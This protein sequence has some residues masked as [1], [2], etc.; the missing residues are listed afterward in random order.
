VIPARLRRPGALA[1]AL[2]TPFFLGLIVVGAATPAHATGESGSI[3]H[4]QPTKDGVRL[5][6][7]AP[8]GSD[9][10]DLAGVK[11]QIG[12]HTVKSEAVTAS[13][14]QATKRVAILAIDTS[15]SM[16]GAR[17]AEAKRAA[18]TYLASAPANVEIGVLTF[19]D[20]VKLLVKPSL[21]RGAAR[22]AINKLTLTHNTALYEGVLGAIQATGAG[23][24]D[25]DQRRILVLSDGK[26]TTQTDL[27][28]VLDTISSS[29]VL[30]DAVA[31]QQ[32]GTES[33]A[34]REMAAAGK[35][36]VLDASSPT[37]LSAAFAQEAAV[38]SRQL[39]VTA[40]VPG[41]AGKNADVSVTMP[42]GGQ[43][44]TAA[45]YLPV[46][47]ATVTAATDMVPTPV[48]SG[49]FQISQNVV[50]GGV[51]AI[52]VGLLGMI[53]A[54][55]SRKPAANTEDRLNAQMSA[56][57]SSAS[58]GGESGPVH[59]QSSGFSG[60]ARGVAERALANNRGLEARLATKLET[61]GLA[62]KPA[63][64]LLLRAGV[65]IAGGL[66]GLLI[67]SG[68][69]M[70]GL[71]LI[72]AGIVGPPLY[73]K[74][75]RSSRL[76]AFAGNLPDTLQLM[77][78][79]L[80][81]GLS[82]AQSIDTI[83][84]EGGEPIAGEFR[85]V[86]IETRLGVP[87]EDSLEGV[88]HRMESRDWEWVVMAIRIQREVGGNLAELLLQ[89]AETLREREFLRRHVRALS[90]EGRLSAYILGGLPPAFLLFL[91]VSKPD[92]VHPLF[93]TSIGFI[94]DIGM[95]LLLGVG[96]LWMSKVAKVNL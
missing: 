64:W 80:S 76:R 14:S 72:V 36:K 46:R 66:L 19:D 24:N 54:L 65:A 94:L 79:S 95:A 31:L 55:W 22:T 7:S 90:A 51:I 85:R 89:V 60:Q 70:L 63:E 18:S 6:V 16:Q 21:D 30:V 92:Y 96:V 68:N 5:L 35:G 9:P 61:A 17:I 20:T 23:G 59:V 50:L 86:V 71:I 11:V 62:F 58:V 38:L 8:P 56:Y 87:L 44:V 27:S 10:V 39:V 12:G 84:R 40:D 48:T 81:A 47:T 67:G 69:I 1:A 73:L 53:I 74:F 78:G 33:Q 26:D 82:L 88:A 2:L 49:A 45:A 29:G 75:K 25:A 34:L 32:S 42:V 43:D 77:S 3:D 13:N 83:V 4:A 91:A 57:G 52:A 15:E 28:D 37:A 93:S 41:S